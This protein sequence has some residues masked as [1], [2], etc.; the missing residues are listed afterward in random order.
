MKFIEKL[1]IYMFPAILLKGTLWEN[2]W[3]EQEKDSF[4]SVMKLFFPIVIVGYVLHYYTVDRNEG[5]APSDL[6][7]R[8]RFGM[9]A[10]CAVVGL[11]Y[12]SSFWMQKLQSY[13]IPFVIVAMTMIYFQTQTVLW[14]SK[15]PYIYSYVFIMT[16]ALIL[17]SDVFRSAL[18]TLVSCAMIFPTLQ[19]AGISPSML[20]S[21]SFFSVAVVVLSRSKYLAEIRYFIL[22][23]KNIAQQKEMIELSMEFTNQIKAFLPFQIAQ[24]LSRSIQSRRMNVSQAIDEILKPK[25]IHVACL[26]SDI[27][28]FTSSSNDLD[29]FVQKAMLPNVKL[30]TKAIENFEGISRKIGD[31]IFAY[32]DADSMERNIRNV[33]ASA[34]EVSRINKSLNEKLPEDQKV[35]RYVLAS[36]GEAVVG[37]LSSYDSAIEITAIGK[38]VNILARIDELTK[39]EQIKSRLGEGDLILTKD[40]YEFV[41]EYYPAIEIQRIDIKKLALSI[42]NFEELE[43]IYVLPFSEKTYLYIKNYNEIMMELV[44]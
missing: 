33:M 16:L 34:M 27:R 44:A 20:W 6:W 13:R 12:R 5:L 8:Y 15:V 11:I 1:I 30:A 23:Q 39:N 40:L 32:Y 14:Y 24:R 2:L 37:N 35:R 17:N 41:I 9:A 25:K 22:T 26:F 19:L 4:I 36:Y 28:G 42:R 29:G 38:P 18:F 43:E 7:F 3:K 10:L 31:L 21:A